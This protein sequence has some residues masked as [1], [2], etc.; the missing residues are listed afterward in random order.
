MK[1][2]ILVL[3]LLGVLLCFGEEN[4]GGAL[5]EETEKTALYL[6]IQGFVGNWWNG[7]D[8]Y[9][10]PCGWT[11]IQGVSCDMFNGLW[12]ITELSVGPI[13]ENSL[14]CDSNLQFTPPQLFELKHLKSLT[15]FNCFTSPSKHPVTIYDQP[16]EKLDGRL[17]SLELRSNPGLVGKIPESFGLLTKLQSLVLLE[18]GFTGELPLNIGNLTRLKRLVVSGNSLT[19]P[20]PYSFG[21]LGNLLIL[22]LSR[23]SLSGNLPQTLGGMTSLLKLD[24][25]NNKLNGKIPTEIGFLK[26]LTLLDLRENRFSSGLTHS[27]QKLYALEEMVLSNNPIGGDI[28]SIEWKNLQNLVI[29]DLSGLGLSLQVPESLSELKRLR[30]L[31]LSNNSLTGTIPQKLATLPCV[32]ALYLNS[33][34]LSGELKFSYEFYEKLGSRFGA[35]NNPNLCYSVGLMSSSSHV[36]NG[37]KPCQDQEQDIKLLEVNSRDYKLGMDQNPNFS[38]SLGFSS[39]GSADRI[40]CY[41][42]IKLWLLFYCFL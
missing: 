9:P 23:N 34:N 21:G 13:H 22:D 7:S 18:N 38:T 2:S 31:G 27:I 4:N 14:E 39:Y 24:L 12:Y 28:M 15:F 20:I 8:L 10:D 40:C 19:G 35:W 30:F 3:L 5:M 11:P 37:V 6:A 29:L 25:G 17:Q 26:N 32:S 36:P 42:L 33:N 1:I 41:F 16:W